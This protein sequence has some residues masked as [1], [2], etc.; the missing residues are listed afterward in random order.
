MKNISFILLALIAISCKKGD[1]LPTMP[2]TSPQESIPPSNKLVI[3]TDTS[4]FRWSLS[5]GSSISFITATLTSISTDTFYARLVGG[6]QLLDDSPLYVA[7]GSDAYIERLEPDNA[8]HTKQRSYLVEGV[9]SSAIGPLMT[10]QL[11]AFIQWQ[12][13][14]YGTFKLRVNYYPSADSIGRTQ[15]F[16]D[17]S[18]DFTIR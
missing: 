1:S 12:P 4:S 14:E 5:E 17:Y 7:E 16:V 10:Y 2:Q 11:Q 13:P 8:W 18:N 9:R 15:R 3:R 6:F